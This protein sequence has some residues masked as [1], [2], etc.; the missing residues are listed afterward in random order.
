MLPEEDAQ[1]LGRRDQPAEHSI[2]IDHGQAGLTVPDRLHAAFSWLR[3]GDHGWVG[4]HQVL[5]G[6]IVVGAGQALDR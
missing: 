5:G 6:R 1:E 4:I 3:R 2:G